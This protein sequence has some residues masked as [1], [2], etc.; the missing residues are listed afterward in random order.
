MVLS[1]WVPPCT[2]FETLA[3]A[4]IVGAVGALWKIA[5]ENVAM[6][7]GLKLG[8]DSVIH[9][10]KSLRDELSKDIRVLEDDIKDH[11]FRIRD[12]EKKQ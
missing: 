6:R 3:A 7:T 5:M 11:E 10:L 8:M 2:V 9:E 4:G 1:R 12:L